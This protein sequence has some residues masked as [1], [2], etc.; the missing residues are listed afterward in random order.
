MT[1]LFS[2]EIVGRAVMF[3]MELVLFRVGI[4]HCIEGGICSCSCSLIHFN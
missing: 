3:L 1:D 2:P 4:E